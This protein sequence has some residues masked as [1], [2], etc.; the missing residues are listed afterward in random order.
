M[1]RGTGSSSFARLQW[2]Q[3][4]EGRSERRGGSGAGN[5]YGRP[6]GAY[7][8]P[9]QRE[10]VARQEHRCVAAPENAAATSC[11]L[12]AGGR[13]H[14]LDGLGQAIG[15]RASTNFGIKIKHI[16]SDNGTEF[17]NTG[18][19]DYLDELGITHEL[20]G[21]Y[22]PQQNGVVERKNMTLGEMARTMLEE[23]QTPRRFWPEAINTACH[24]INRVYLHKFLKK[25]SYELLTDKKPNVSYFKV[26]GAKCWIRDPHHSSKFAPKAHEGFMLGYGKDSH[27]YRVF[28]NYH[29]KV[30]ETVDVRFDETNGSQRE[31]LP[32]DPDKLSPEEAIK[33]KPTE[34]IVPTEE[35]GEETIPI[36][37]KNQEDAPEEIATAPLPQPRQNPQPAHPR[38]A[39]EVELDKIL[40]DINAPAF[41]EET[42]QGSSESSRVQNHQQDPQLK[43]MEEERKQKGGKKLEQNTAAD[44][45][46]DI[47]L[48]Y[49]TPDEHA[50]MAKRKIRL[51]K[52]ERRWAKEWKEYK[53]VTRKYAKK[54]A[55]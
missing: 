54:F 18:L 23:Y 7:P 15:D 40:N 12:L 26:F 32:S 34:D 49:C 50:T 11:C 16:R 35:I 36:A 20:S 30:V 25:N 9:C 28:N 39:N 19:D 48:D 24:I 4:G 33:L 44:I 46:E 45:P 53:F 10:T 22:T 47:Y 55:L 42:V 37:D 14:G 43:K 13:R 2:R 31:Q 3:K 21:P 27:T 5:G 41:L 29:N 52:I 1:A 17:K 51:Q 6:R 38:I 8:R